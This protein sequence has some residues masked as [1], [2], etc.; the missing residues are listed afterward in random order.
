MLKIIRTK[1][2]DKRVVITLFPVTNQIEIHNKL[3]K[4]AV[5]WSHIFIMITNYD[6]IK[7]EC[8]VIFEKWDD[9]K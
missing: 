3:R 5:K 1:R 9:A 7:M 8:E 4:V 2:T 6:P